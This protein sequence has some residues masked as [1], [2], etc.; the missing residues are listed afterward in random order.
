MHPNTSATKVAWFQNLGTAGFSQE[1]SLA[2]MAHQGSY[3]V[4]RFCVFDANL[5]GIT[6]VVV[7]DN[8][9]SRFLLVRGLGNSSFAHQVTMYDEPNFGR[10]Y[11]VAPHD[12]DGDGRL[13]IVYGENTDSLINNEGYHRISWL[14]NEYPAPVQGLQTIFNNSTCDDNNTPLD[15]TDD[16]QVLHFKVTTIGNGAFSNRYVLYDEL[17]QTALD[18]FLYDFMASYTLSPGSA[19]ISNARSY[20]FRDLNNPDL[21]KAFNKP[22]IGNCSPEA[23]TAIGVNFFKATCDDSS[24]P[25]DP[26]DDR[27]KFELDAARYNGS[28]NSSG[29]SLNSNLG[30]PASHPNELNTGNYLFPDTFY[31][32]DGSASIPGEVTITIQDQ[33]NAGITK[34]IIFDNPGTCFSVPP[35]CPTDIYYTKQRQVDLFPITYP[36]CKVI[37]GSV[38]MRQS[39]LPGAQELENL[40]GFSNLEY[41]HGDFTI[42]ETNLT[43]L[44][45]LESLKKVGGD[46]LISGNHELQTLEGLNNLEEIGKSLS[47]YNST[48]LSTLSGL[49]SLN[50]IGNDLSL[51]F[52]PIL[53][54]L[55]SL[56]KLENINGSV[57]LQGLDSLRSLQGLDNISNIGSAAETF[58]GQLAI[59]DC[60]SLESLDN[61]AGLESLSTLLLWENRQLKNLSGLQNLE[62]I[63]TE[64]SILQN[65]VLDNLDALSNVTSSLKVFFISDNDKLTQLDG[66]KN[67]NLLSLI[68]F[69]I[70]GSESLSGCSQP[71]ICDYLNSGKFA[72]VEFNK[73][74]CNS[75]NEIQSVCQ[76]PLTAFLEG[77]TEICQGDSTEL[78]ITF[79]GLAPYSFTIS[80]NGTPLP[81]VITS[82][83]PYLI[84]VNPDIQ[85]AYS[86]VNVSNE[87]GIGLTGGTALILTHPLPDALINAPDTVCLGDT[88]IITASGGQDYVWSTGHSGSQIE[89]LAESTKT[90]SVTVTDEN[91]CSS[92]TSKTIE[93]KECTVGTFSMGNDN[94]SGNFHVFPNPLSKDDMLQIFLQ[95]NFTG[96]LKIEFSSLDGRVLKTVFAKKEKSIFMEHFSIDAVWPGQFIVRVTDGERSGARLV[97]RF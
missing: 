51:R 93:V 32:P 63:R 68:V 28:N 56:Q 57:W 30:L 61:L 52:A 11:G 88:I 12:V 35:P 36:S 76:V 54:D 21:K 27:I 82:E 3:A 47:V 83:N 94:E 53:A 45:G 73:F 25:T 2:T 89:L 90:Y 16:R 77:S 71:N 50:Q 49:D 44:N 6:D 7:S 87:L 26:S 38:T 17:A 81:T 24:T 55:S 9:W 8:Y 20:S 46:F 59:L 78:K 22:A 62:T 74:G 14:K 40:D 58:S 64:L 66:I 10:F 43:D 1:K 75:M 92:I 86:L 96:E 72:F 33:M 31:L 19:G 85:S 84:E 4:P 23:P 95:N 5:D 65:P 37:E 29:Y 18:T 39:M 80:A 97:M 70:S 67:I 15:A 60:H 48:S 42:E 91:L 34:T 69:E 13:D 41:I 79:D